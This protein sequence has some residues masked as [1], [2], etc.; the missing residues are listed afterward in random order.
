MF[1]A[2]IFQSLY[3][4]L[5]EKCRNKVLGNIF[6]VH[7]V[8][9]TDFVVRESAVIFRFF[10]DGVFYQYVFDFDIKNDNSFIKVSCSRDVIYSFISVKE[11]FNLNCSQ[12]FSLVI[13][14]FQCQDEYRIY[15]LVRLFL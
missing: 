5:G 9:V 7:D 15:Q 10:S 12:L 8:S 13:E 2:L 6:G 1:G 14:M 3:L 11:E 4:N